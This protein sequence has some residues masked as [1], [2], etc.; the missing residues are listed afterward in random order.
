MPKFLY[1]I[2]L[3]MKKKVNADLIMLLILCLK[4]KMYGAR[5]EKSFLLW[6]SS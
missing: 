4:H 5:Y 2:E 6:W 3:G 1:K